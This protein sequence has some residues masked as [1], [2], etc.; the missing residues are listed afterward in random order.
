MWNPFNRKPKQVKSN[1]EDDKLWDELWDERLAAL[2][3]LY[4]KSDDMVGHGVVPFY[5]GADVG[6]A[7]DIVYFLSHIPG[8]L[9]VTAELIGC[10]DQKHGPLGN[11]E[12]AIAHRDANEWGP[13]LISRLAHYTLDA[14]LKPAETMDIAP[15]TPEDSTIDALMFFDYGTFSFRS[16]RAGVLLCVGITEKEKKACLAGKSTAVITALKDKG[17]FPY[18]DL[19]RDSVI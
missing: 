17:V 14:V 11:Y 8:R 2:E 16:R 1:E 5:L 9:S 10:E 7:A 4:G 3:A 15:A 19:T 18:T 13:D 12:L 6:G